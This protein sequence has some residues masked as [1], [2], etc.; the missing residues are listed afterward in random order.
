MN[1]KNRSERPYLARLAIVLILPVALMVYATAFYS[2]VDHL[3]VTSRVYPQALILVLVLV[4]ASLVWTDVREWARVDKHPRLRET[5]NRWQRSATTAAWTAVFIWGIE[6]VGFYGA[7][8]LYML[9][10]MPLLGVRRPAV[11]V[12]YTAGTTLGLYL[13]FDLTLRVRLP[14]GLLI[15]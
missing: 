1:W 15:G 13:L 11:I 4:L 3:G 10:L 8:T 14:E 7:V 5:W 9:V 2:T 12:A 6:R